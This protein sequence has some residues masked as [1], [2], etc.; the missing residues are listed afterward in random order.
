MSEDYFMYN[1][2]VLT[3]LSTKIFKK[4]LPYFFVDPKSNNS[5]VIF[6]FSQFTTHFVFFGIYF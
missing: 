3:T 6:K 5:L 4:N 1:T 2:I